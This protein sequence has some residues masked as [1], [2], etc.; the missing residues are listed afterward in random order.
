MQDVCIAMWSEIN[1]GDQIVKVTDVCSTDPDDDTHCATPNDIKVDR[2]KVYV[3]YNLTGPGIDNADLQKPVYPRTVYWHFTKCWLMA[4][5]QPAYVDNWFAQPPLPNNANWDVDATQMQMRNN[6]QS[7]PGQGWATYPDGSGGP[8]AAS[9]AGIVPIT[10]WVPGQE[11]A[12]APIAGGKGYGTPER[13]N[14]PPPKLYPGKSTL[15]AHGAT[16]SSAAETSDS[17]A[18]NTATSNTDT[19]NNGTSNIDTS[20]TGTS[21]T[22]TS[23]DETD[24]TESPPFCDEL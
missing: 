9:V 15:L 7:Y 17:A 6:Q 2:A 10:D 16:N 12:W 4:L 8:D 22:G 19:S 3:L 14:G 24:E 1:A 21:N 13:S 23:S 11:P 18:N 20:S 5:P